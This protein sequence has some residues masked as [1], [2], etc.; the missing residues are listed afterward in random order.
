MEEEMENPEKP[1]EALHLGY[2]A[3]MGMLLKQELKLE[4]SSKT[5]PIDS[6]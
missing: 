5:H 2:C 6:E 4:D 1:E 3:G